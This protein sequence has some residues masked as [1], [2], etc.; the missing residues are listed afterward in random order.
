M[1]LCIVW[2]FIKTKIYS[3]VSI[4]NKNICQKIFQKKW[5]QVWFASVF[6]PSAAAAG[7][8]LKNKPDA[9]ALQAQTLSNATPPIGK[10]HPLRKIAITLEPEMR[11]GYPMKF[12]IN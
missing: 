1:S 6:A 7:F 12:R 4:K 3:L 2:K 5:V 8:P 11:F 9:Q 10:I